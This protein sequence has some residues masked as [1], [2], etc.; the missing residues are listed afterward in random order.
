MSASSL[1]EADLP[2]RIDA[3][4]LV[5]GLSHSDLMLEITEDF[6]MADQ[7]R[8][9]D[10]LV[11]LRES[12]IR[13]AVDDFGTGYSSL[14][15]LLDLP[16]DELKLDKSFVFP[17]AD[18]ARAAALVASI[19]DLAHSLGMSLVAE[20]VEDAVAYDELV[21]YGCDEAQGFHMSRPVPAAALDEWLLARSQAV[22]VGL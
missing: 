8:A 21:R 16:I 4:I 5:R 9:W 11:R 6:L 3:M 14:A 10:I 2:E 12:G 22:T 15:Y 1:T 18:D 7:D 19:I 17:M 13:I 20:G